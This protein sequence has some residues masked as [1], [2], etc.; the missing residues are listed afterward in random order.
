METI[1]Y[2][3]VRDVKSPCRAHSTD[4]G[5]DFFVPFGISLDTM[6]EKFKTTGCSVD[7]EVDENGN[8]ICFKLKPNESVLIPSG[9]K[10]K[11]PDGYMLQFNNKSGIA[12]KRSL[13]VGS[14]IVDIAYEGECHINLHNVSDKEQII[15]AGDKIVQG[16]LVKVG[17]HQPEEVE[18]EEILFKGSTS[19]RK[20]NGFGSTGTN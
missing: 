12:A 20:E 2:C 19:E 6:K 17:F 3:K 14:S 11:V 10:I 15:S 1:K 16:I 7:T 13:L 9:I 4:A 5:I 8:V 18:N